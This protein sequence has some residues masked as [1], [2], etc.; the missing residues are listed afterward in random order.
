MNQIFVKKIDVKKDTSFAEA[1]NR[2]EWQTVTHMIQTLN[3]KEFS[4]LP[5]VNFRIA[6]ADDEIL[7]K[8]Y[9]AEKHLRARETRI[10]GDVYKDSCVEFFISPDGKDYYNFEFSCI[11]TIH[12]GY[13]PGRGNRKFVDPELV[14][15]I[16]IR[17]SLGSAPFND[18][19]GDFEWEMMIRIPVEVFQYSNLK[20]FDGLKA[21]ANFYKCGDE[22]A[23]AHYVTWNPVKTENPDYHQPAFFGKLEFE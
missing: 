18:K 1:E 10:N 14:K 22:T 2:L 8:Y 4:Y 21:S 20:S 11:G 17:S 3:W 7:L 6:H 9:V 19:S 5:V 23:V 15:K 12:L 16:E 13:G